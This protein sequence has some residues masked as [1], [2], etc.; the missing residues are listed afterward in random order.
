MRGKPLVLTRT[1][2]GCMVPTSHKLNQ[3]GYYRTRDPRDTSDGRKRPIMMHRYVWEM[4]YGDIPKGKEI[5]HK[6]HNRACCNLDHLEL[7]DIIEHKK[8]HNHTR[9]LPRKESAKEYWLANQCSGTK[10]AEVYGVS[11]SS[12]CK[13]LREWKCRD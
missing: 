9:Y 8:E 2:E 13:W 6:C 7:V 5:H 12:A 10:L 3:D 4:A 11:W 1:K